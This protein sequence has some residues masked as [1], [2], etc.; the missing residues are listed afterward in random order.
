MIT[1]FLFAA[2]ANQIR[3]EFQAKAFTEVAKAEA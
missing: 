1:A 3:L 2:I